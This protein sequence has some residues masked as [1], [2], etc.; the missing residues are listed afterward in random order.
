MVIDKKVRELYAA[1]TTR[2][3]HLPFYRPAQTYIVCILIGL[4][5]LAMHALPSKI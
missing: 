4:E 3:I 5:L 1:P 2:Y